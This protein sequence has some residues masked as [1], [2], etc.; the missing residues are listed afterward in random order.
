MAGLLVLYD[1][2]CGICTALAGWIRRFEIDAEPI[3]SDTGRHWLRDLDDGQ[4][5]ASAHVVDAAG[6]R[7]SGGG[8]VAVVARELPGGWLLGRV[9][10][11]L[12]GLTAFGYTVVAEH[13]G[14]LSR[15]AG[16]D[17]CA[18]EAGDDQDSRRS[19]P[20]RPPEDDPSQAWHRTGTDRSH[21]RR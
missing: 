18:V 14:R 16:L 10:S 2:D 1:E 21:V 20:L 17:R 15:L 13:R 8:A 7:T 19:P 9:A 12:P 11:G 5:Y 6:R 3:G 4:R